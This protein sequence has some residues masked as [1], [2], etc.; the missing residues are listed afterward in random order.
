M[1]RP[2][3]QPRSPRPLTSTLLTKPMRTW[4]YF[5]STDKWLLLNRNNYLKP[6]CYHYQNIWNHVTV[7]K[8]FVL[9]K[10]TC[11]QYHHH[12][13]PLARISLN[14]SRHFVVFWPGQKCHSRWCT[15]R[16]WHI[17]MAVMRG[18]RVGGN[19][20]MK[21]DEVKKNPMILS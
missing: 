18:N 16:K 8:L 4:S 1:T 7:Y 14:L 21:W 3:V 11:Y 13:V 10:S 15:G 6:Y 20:L 9:D 5:I 12:V 17:L 19:W 2:R